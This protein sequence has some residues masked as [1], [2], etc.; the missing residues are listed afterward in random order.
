[1]PGP[2]PE[3]TQDNI[4]DTHSIPRKMLK[5]PDPTGNATRDSGF[6]GRD[7][8]GDATAT[9]IWNFTC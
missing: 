3:T 2:L 6:V 1:M 7:S 5:N 4:R 8:T 9:D